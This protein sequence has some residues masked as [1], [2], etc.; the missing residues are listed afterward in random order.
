M[1]L[2]FVFQCIQKPCINVLSKCVLYKVTSDWS[3]V[4]SQEHFTYIEALS[5]GMVEETGVR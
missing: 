4:M 1:K 2:I 3:G 5:S